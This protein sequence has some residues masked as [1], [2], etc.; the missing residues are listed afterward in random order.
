MH[1]LLQEITTQNGMLQGQQANGAHGK[2]SRGSYSWATKP[3][4]RVSSG[5]L[6][7]TSHFVWTRHEVASK[8]ITPLNKK[9]IH[10]HETT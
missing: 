1:G 8:I 2:F 7:T 5:V 3:P 9:K 10:A 4:T 6:N